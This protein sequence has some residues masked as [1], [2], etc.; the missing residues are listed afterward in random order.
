MNR[1]TLLLTFLLSLMFSS[2]SYSAWMKFG[3]S[4]RGNTFYV[5]FERIRKVDGFVYVWMLTDL[6]KST[7]YG[8]LSARTY[9]QGDCKLFRF[10]IL[11][12]IWHE[13]PMGRNTGKTT[14][15]KNPEWRFPSPNSV[16]ETILKSV[17]SR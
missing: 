16:N 3:E 9:I 7:E 8:D 2:P 15:P 17:C 6:L 4:V 5:D 14:T 10:K 12:Q 11:S 1:Y 13:Q